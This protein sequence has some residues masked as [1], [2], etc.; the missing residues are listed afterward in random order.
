MKKIISLI[1]L[2]SLIPLISLSQN[3]GINPTGATPNSSAGL[4]VDFTNKGVLIPRVALTGVNDAATIPSPATSLIVYNNGS[5]GLS[6]AGYYYN[7]NTPGSPVWSQLL[8]GGTSFCSG[9]AANYV[10]KFTSASAICNSIIYDNG[11]NVGISTTSPG[12]KLDVQGGTSFGAG[13]F[14]SG[15]VTDIGNAGIDYPGNGG[16]AGSYNSNLL[17]SGLDYTTISFHDAGATV[18]ELGHVSNNFFFDGGQAWGPVSLGINTRAPNLKMEILS[19]NSDGIVMGQQYDNTN[20]IQTYIDGQWTNRATYAGGCCN[21][22]LLQPDVGEVA[23]GTTSAAEKL[24]VNGNMKFTGWAHLYNGSSNFH[25]DASSTGSMYLNYYS[26]ANVFFGTGASN[27]TGVWT[28]AG[29]VGIGTTGPAVRCEI[30]SGNNTE[31]LRMNRSAGNPFQILFGDNLAGE[32]NADGVVYFEIGGSES[33]VMGGHTMPDSDNGRLL[34]TSAHRWQE[35]W[36]A[37]GVIQTSDIREKEN[38]KSAPYG[39]SEIMKLNP[40]SFTW[41]KF[42][43]QNTKLGFSAQELQQ[44][45]PEVVRI[46]DNPD[47]PLGIM[48]SDLIPVLTKAIQQQQKMIEQLQQSNTNLAQRMKSMEE[49]AQK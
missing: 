19:G 18:G 14:Q 10:T 31:F 21:K 9:A 13:T 37:N 42:P 47:A 35:V 16:W 39:L 22:L 40:I 20:T 27:V 6:P 5:G 30:V 25:I 29:N 32:A 44:V 15:A 43:L 1:P 3:V 4:D 36:A 17:L 12:K 7:S 46:P 34:G 45:I 23:I 26:G 2:L 48:Y 28:S 38:I 41:K 24:E 11:T 49:K 33:Y 8:N